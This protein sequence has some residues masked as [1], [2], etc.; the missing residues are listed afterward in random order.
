MEERK[1]TA[2]YSKDKEFVTIKSDDFDFLL[3]HVEHT[4]QYAR[5]GSLFDMLYGHCG[6]EFIYKKPIQNGE[7]EDIKVTLC[8]FGIRDNDIK[9]I[10]TK[11]RKDN[12][13]WFFEDGTYYDK[14]HA[15]DDGDKCALFPLSGGSWYRYFE[16]HNNYVDEPE[17]GEMVIALNH[18]IYESGERWET[19]IKPYIANG[20]VEDRENE[21]GWVFSNDFVYKMADIKKI[22]DGGYEELPNYGCCKDKRLTPLMESLIRGFAEVEHYFYMN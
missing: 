10:M 12:D 16:K 15:K 9:V 3:S 17:K 2:L 8:G 1:F 14:Y 5:S 20:I 13:Y 6:K 11:D 4:K 7:T 21:E 22:M 19:K 18:H